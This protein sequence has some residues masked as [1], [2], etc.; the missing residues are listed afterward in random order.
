MWNFEFFPFL[1]S[2]DN[3]FLW[4]FQDQVDQYF[5]EESDDDDVPDELKSDCIDEFE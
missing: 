1:I 4:F 3:F 2:E 5:S